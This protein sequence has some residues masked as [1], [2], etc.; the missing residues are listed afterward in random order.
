[1]SN[2]DGDAGSELDQIGDQ[3]IDRKKADLAVQNLADARLW[4]APNFGKVILAVAEL[5]DEFENLVAE[6]DLMVS[7]QILREF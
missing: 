7:T 3:R 5:T 1:M 2:R 6:V 4:F